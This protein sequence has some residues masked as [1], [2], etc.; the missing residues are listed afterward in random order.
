MSCYLAPAVTMMQ[1]TTSAKNAGLV[2][3]AETFF[4]YISQTIAPAVFGSLA[5]RFGA[6]NNPRVY[7]YIVFSAMFL[8]SMLSN[9]FYL[10]AGREYKKVMMAKDALRAANDN[11]GEEKLLATA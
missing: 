7:G 10:R 8:G 5:F 1:N 6:V 2:V 9:F 3:S 11:Y 4:S